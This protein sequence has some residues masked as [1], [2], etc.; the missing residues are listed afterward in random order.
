[1]ASTLARRHLAL[2]SSSIRASIQI[3]TGWRPQYATVFALGALLLVD[4]WS[5]ERAGGAFR[6]SGRSVVPL[7]GLQGDELR[8][9]L[10]LPDRGPLHEGHLPEVGE[11]DESRSPVP[12]DERERG[13]AGDPF[14]RGLPWT[15]DMALDRI[16]SVR[17]G[18]HYRPTLDPISVLDAFQLVAVTSYLG[19][20]LDLLPQRQAAPG[21]HLLLDDPAR[22]GDPSVGSVQFVIARWEH[23]QGGDAGREGRLSFVSWCCA[24]AP[25]YPRSRSARFPTVLRIR[26]CPSWR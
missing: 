11:D 24:A 22:R 1:M 4:Q 15:A 17:E 18:T 6:R 12:G 8:L 9:D 7:P 13:C 26:C 20:T 21:R 3:D 5:R 19:S 14:S 2:H 10:R 16:M 25:C 23:G